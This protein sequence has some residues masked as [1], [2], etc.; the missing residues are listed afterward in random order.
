[1]KRVR[2]TAIFRRPVDVA[3]LAEVLIRQVRQAALKETSNP[4]D[5]GGGGRR[6]GEPRE[7]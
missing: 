2:I 6:E 1:M 5:G 7:G 4:G 3:R